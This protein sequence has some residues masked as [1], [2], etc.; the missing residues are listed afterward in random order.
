MPPSPISEA[1][2]SCD[3]AGAPLPDA[4][5]PGLVRRLLTFR[6]GAMFVRNT[7]VSCVAFAF[8]LALLA[9]LVE[10][11]AMH[12]LAAV[13]LAFLAAV[14]FH[15]VLGRVWIFPGSERGVTAGYVY[16]IVNAT[17]GLVVTVAL[18]AA[19]VWLGLH[20][21]PARIVASVFAGLT[22]FLLNAVLNFRSV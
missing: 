7:I 10:L 22:V 13:T 20:Y 21:I 15:Y 12:K 17:I 5:P 14:T 19:F 2:D 11:L 8:D 3:E 4:R 16:F 6:V 18:F 1:V 9:A